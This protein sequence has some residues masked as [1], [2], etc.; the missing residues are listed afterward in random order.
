[1]AKK[2]YVDLAGLQEYDKGLKDSLSK[3]E[4][5][6]IN[7]TS[8]DEIVY[9]EIGDIDT[10]SQTA[11]DTAKS[12]IDS[13]KIVVMIDCETDRYIATSS[14]SHSISFSTMYGV[15]IWWN[16]TKKTEWV[17]YVSSNDFDKHTHN[18]NDLEN[19]PNIE[20]D[21]QDDKFS[22]TDQ[23]GNIIAEIDKNG[24]NSVDFLIKGK[25]MTKIFVGTQAE[26]D[27]LIASNQIPIGSLVVVNGE[28]DGAIDGG[29]SGGSGGSGDSD[30]SS[31]VIPTVDTLENPTSDSPS[32]VMFEDSLY[33]LVDDEEE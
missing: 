26:I 2:K 9:I 15:C 27:A 16:D 18:F 14:D 17:E 19:K 28:Y 11:Y 3:L 7:N 5:K 29:S 30:G 8:K 31:G 32:F 21:D 33:V 25:P 23:N 20:T 6:I 13:N 12:A 10:F 24:V 1:M 22:I 4:S